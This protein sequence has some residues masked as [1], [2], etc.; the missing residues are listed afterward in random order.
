MSVPAGPV[1]PAL[2]EAA[3]SFC[4]PFEVAAES[5]RT[6]SLVLRHA[7][8]DARVRLRY[9]SE[10]GLFL[11][12][13]YLVIEAEV[14]GEGPEDAGELVLRRR[15]LG[16]KRPKPE[17]ATAWRKHVVSE[18]LR[19]S[20]RGLQVERL[21]IRWAPERATWNVSLETLSGSLTVT[22]FPPLATPN[23]LLREEA[24]AFL[25]LLGALRAATSGRPA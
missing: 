17:G 1:W 8:A 11:R 19:A 6:L 9:R 13:Y 3:R 5:P 12:T 22:F 20:L 14:A 10:R 2:R 25:S 23:P 4:P 7:D 18:E 24:E 16:W 15:R 21:G